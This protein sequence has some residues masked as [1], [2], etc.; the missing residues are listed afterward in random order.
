[1]SDSNKTLTTT[2][3]E[4]AVMEYLGWRRN[5]VVPNISTS[6]L[7]Y[8]ADV[9]SLTPSLWATEVEIKISKADLLADFKKKRYH[10]SPMFR[11]FYYAVPLWMQDFALEHI[12][13]RAGLIVVRKGEY[14]PRLLIAS[15]HRTA[16]PNPRCRQLTADERLYLARLGAMRICGLKIAILDERYKNG[17]EESDG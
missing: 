16:K 14:D 2:E 12:S 8:E 17:K 4:I 9:V 15:L 11:Q 1:M 13:D 6:F 3:M 10:D 7:P 5:I